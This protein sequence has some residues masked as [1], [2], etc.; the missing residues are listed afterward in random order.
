MEVKS[1]VNECYRL[2]SPL[3]GRRRGP[4]VVSIAES[5]FFC[6]T[7]GVGVRRPRPPRRP[8]PTAATLGAFIPAHDCPL[9]HAPTDPAPRIAT[10]A[11]GVRAVAIPMPWRSTVSLSVFVRT[12]SLHESRPANGIS[13]VVEHMAFK[14]TLSRDCQRIN[15]DAE[16]LGAEVNA[17]TDKDHT[18]FHI[19]GLPRDLGAFVAQLADIV[20]NSTFPEEELERERQVIEHEFTE[21]EDDPA[22]MAFQ[23]FDRACYGNHPA[24]QPVIGNRA[25]LK[26]FTRADLL[27]YVKRQYTAG[28]VVVAAAGPVDFDAFVRAVESAFGG[29]P[30]GTP[31]EVPPPPAWLGGL[32]L[33][34]MA[35]SSQCQTVVGFEAPAL[36]D[37]RHLPH[38]LAAALLGEGMSSPLLDEIRE[39]R[40]LAYYVSCSADILPLTGQFVVEAATAPAQAVEFLDEVAHL[41][42]R[43]AEGTDAVGFE[44]ARNQI[45]VRTLRALEQP[46][47]R[48]EA[49]AQDLFTFGQLRDTRD[50]LAQLQ[51]VSAQDVRQVFSEMLA[52]PAAI[53][54]AGSVPAKARERAEA[55]FAGK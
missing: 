20:L 22:A 23:L 30:P 45:T 2:E 26:R 37:A 27:G 25:N 28:N 18:A 15:L 49:A 9:D 51:T 21:F 12:G 50:W 10:L 7:G 47:R 48:L 39:R 53:A 44:R 24:G 3:S 8:P 35:G 40:G 42:R 29:M 5:L 52:R 11:N 19:E 4:G 31:N 55:L 6:W 34:R 14:G 46:A 43:H 33:R 1:R 54:L 13:H 41:L 32:K 16:R 38:V 36:F 17:H